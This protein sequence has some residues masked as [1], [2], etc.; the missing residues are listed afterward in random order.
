MIFDGRNLFRIIGRSLYTGTLDV[1]HALTCDCHRRT[2]C[3]YRFLFCC[4]VSQGRCPRTPTNFLKKVRS[5]TSIFKAN[6]LY[7]NDFSNSK[8]LDAAGGRLTPFKLTI[9]ILLAGIGSAKFTSNTFFC[10]SSSAQNS[11]TMQESP[12]LMRASSPISS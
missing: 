10:R 11:R 9:P 1:C 2:L 5:K 7:S 6:S 8:N 3:I 4:E 12:R